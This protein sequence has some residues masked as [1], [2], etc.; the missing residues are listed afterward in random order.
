LAL[1]V[2]PTRELAVQIH[3]ESERFAKAV[4]CRS[5]CLYGGAAWEEQAALLEAGVELLVA[6]PGRLAFLIGR[7][8]EVVAQVV[9]TI[10]ACG[11]RKQLAE[12]TAAFDEFI[13]D[14]GVPTRRVYSALMNA[15]V[16]C[17]DL[18]GASI[19][20]E[21]MQNSG[22]P[23]GV[24][25]STMLLKGELAAGNFLNAKEI[26]SDMQSADPPLYPDLRTANTFLRGCLKLGE[27]PEVDD[28]FA[29]LQEWGIVP[30]ATTYKM[31]MESYGQGLRLKDMQRLLREIGDR[32][33]V[34][35]GLDNEAGLNLCIA[36]VACLLGQR[37]A[38][39]K[40][41][42]RAQIALTRALASQGEFEQLRRNEFEHN[43][44][45]LTAKLEEGEDFDITGC[46]QRTF[47]FPALRGGGSC[48][49][50]AVYD[51][52]Q[53]GFGV[54]QCFERELC[55]ESDFKT[56]L[57]RCFHKSGALR[58]PRVFESKRLP[59]KLEVCSGTGDWVVAQ[60]L[61]EAD[62]AN[63]VASELRYDRVCSILSKAALA[64]VDNL[65]LL[66]GDAGSIL[67]GS[68]PAGSL[69]H[70]C[71]NFPE[72]PQTS[73][74]S[75]CDEAESQLH[76][77]TPS[78][79]ADVHAALEDAGALTIFSDNREYMRS[80]AGTL[81]GLC[82]RDYNRLFCPSPHVPERMLGA[83]ERCGGVAVCKG[84]P[85]PKLG[86]AAQATSQFDRFFQHGQHTERYFIA[87]TKA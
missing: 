9:R 82:D 76:L 35:Q 26:L 5:A 60:A 51:A 66:A 49:H 57:S 45:I 33:D 30:D 1:V 53:R 52:L 86:H 43:A 73:R 3:R 41:L 80:L 37:K 36:N 42:Q 85:G 59:T 13:A 39:K 87:V 71:V 50:T 70:V 15:R 14:G 61:A 72:P 40:A 18:A 48:V 8:G 28:F 77:L 38:G 47:A 20:A 16:N 69:S 62:Q 68:V 67:R 19:I 31:V 23:L 29:R 54:K 63:W 24:V 65:C 78:F 34:L 46:L 25:E 56:R 58:W 75:S 64:R 27:L 81:G 7:G 84:C 21:E 12:A 11:A 10:T 32:A 4:G 17:S 55:I 74:N 22:F 6:T 44:E 83:A 2:V 79:F